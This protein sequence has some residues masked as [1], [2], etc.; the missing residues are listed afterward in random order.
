MS[1]L[2][3]SWDGLEF[4]VAAHLGRA[5]GRI[6]LD[7][8]NLGAGGIAGFAVGQLAGQHRHAGTL[9]LFD[10]LR[11]TLARLRPAD[12]EFGQLLAVFDI[13]VQPQVER[14]LGE[15]AHRAHGVAAVQA[16]LDL[17]LE[18]R[19]QHLGR[20]HET[21]AREHVLGQQLDALGQQAVQLGKALDRAEQ[22]F[23]QARLVGAAGRRRDQVD[24][25]LAHRVAVFGPG[26]HPLGALAFGEG[27]V[28]GAGV[29]LALEERHHQLGARQRLDR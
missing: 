17:A 27:F 19:V 9:A 2:P 13:A 23:A 29:L 1:T 26:H 3:R 28:V 7:Q 21:G 5:A 18:L 14:A 4:L 10:L 6:A 11:R 8:E 15:P 12:G 24:V 25:R 22:A 20:Q 16:F